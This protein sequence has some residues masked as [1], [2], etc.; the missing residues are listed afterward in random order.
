MSEEIDSLKD[1]ISLS[2]H[3]VQRGMNGKA[4]ALAKGLLKVLTSGYV[5]IRL[6]LVLVVPS[7]SLIHVS[8][9]FIF[10]RLLPFKIKI[11]IF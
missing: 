4:Y 2:F 1:V 11:K 10:F 5:S 6:F 3:Y 9:V 8:S 7:G